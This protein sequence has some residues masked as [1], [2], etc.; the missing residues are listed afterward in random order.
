MVNKEDYLKYPGSKV[1]FTEA[2]LSSQALYSIKPDELSVKLK[3]W[4]LLADH[5]ILSTG[6]MIPSD[7]TYSWL[8]D[9]SDI[10]AELSSEKAILP[11]LSVK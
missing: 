1:Y 11:S 10:V 5:V 2:D 8:H 3:L 7:M 9:N 6:H 4:L